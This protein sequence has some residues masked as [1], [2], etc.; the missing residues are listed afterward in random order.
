MIEFFQVDIH[1]VNLLDQLA[2]PLQHAE[3]FQSEEVH[4]QQADLLNRRPVELRHE[5][6]L[7]G[8]PV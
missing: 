3:R 6:I 4:L 1:P 7:I 8:C 5:R 2:R